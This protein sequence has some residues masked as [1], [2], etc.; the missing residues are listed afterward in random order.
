M[1]DSSS[2]CVEA[3]CLIKSQLVALMAGPL[4]QVRSENRVPISVVCPL[5]CERGAAFA[6]D[7]A[8]KGLKLFEDVFEMPYPLPK[9]DLGAV[10][11]FSTGAT[12]NWGLI[13]FRKNTLLLDIEDSSLEKEA[14]IAETV[15]HELAHMWFGNL[16]TMK[17]WDGLWLKEGFATLM[18]W[19]A[20]DKLFP[21]CNGWEEYI[22]GPLQAALEL[23]SLKRS[24]PVDMEI[25]EGTEAKQFYD[26]ISYKK[27]CLVLMMMVSEVG[28][29]SF[30]RGIKL[31]LKRYAYGNTIS[32]DLWS[33]IEEATAVPMRNK[34]R[35]WIKRP[36]YPVVTVREVTE[37]ETG[38]VV[39]LHIRQDRFLSSH[40]EEAQASEDAYPLRLG[41][42]SDT[43]TQMVDAHSK[44]MT[45]RTSE[46]SFL[47]VNADHTAFCRVSYSTG[48]LRKLTQAA[49]D[50]R[51]TLRDC[52]GLSCD[53][54][55]LV[56]AG[57]NKT[58]ELLDLSLGLLP[59]DEYLVW[60]MIDRNLRGVQ[61]A[62]KFH[63]DSVTRAI[64][65][66]VVDFIGPKCRE[67]GWEIS[68]EDS[69]DMESFKASMFSTAGLAGD[70]M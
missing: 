5:G 28:L 59:R 45:V 65:N 3:R 54:K 33:S 17:Y 69:V 27:G 31:Y 53:L 63:G 15:L 25:Q 16:V 9:L 49:A 36:G 29:D 6:L 4:A 47:K 44:E 34:M 13:L 21:D 46:S 22:A 52:I 67:L 18:S 56:A 39:A 11:D 26:D 68:E 70:E 35:V 37:G 57:V 43:G 20:A 64:E 14:E 8:A 60:E 38:K 12:E 50:G 55:A 32:D 48:H 19:L 40:D 66:A 41:I 61:A 51:L 58:S 62:F 42:R 1:T 10:P 23:D 7:L 24:H 2:C 30:L